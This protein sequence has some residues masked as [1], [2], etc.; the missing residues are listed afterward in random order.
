VHSRLAY[1]FLVLNAL[2]DQKSTGQTI[3]ELIKTFK[4]QNE[5]PRF[6]QELRSAQD[7]VISFRRELLER[8][9]DRLYTSAA[10]AG[11]KEQRNGT[12]IL[13]NECQLDD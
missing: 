11:Y 4:E 13:E 6:V 1:L 12:S 3:D 7:R 10:N 8:F 2:V 9:S 5:L